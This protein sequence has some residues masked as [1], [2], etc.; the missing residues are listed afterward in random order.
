MA[1]NTLPARIFEVQN[2][3]TIAN[4]PVS[5]HFGTDLDNLACWLVGWD[6]RQL[7]REL[8]LQNLQIGVA[9]SS[10][11]DSDHKVMLAACRHSSLTE[12]IWPVELYARSVMPSYRIDDVTVPL[13]S[14]QPS[15]VSPWWIAIRIRALCLSLAT[16]SLQNTTINLHE[17][18]H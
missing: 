3:D 2:P 17:T 5:L 7:C 1:S 13:L 16:T 10:C 14:L 18:G 8:A 6:H 12:L 11:I 15:F 9:E 4:L